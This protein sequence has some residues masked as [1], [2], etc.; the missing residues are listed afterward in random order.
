MNQ[1]KYMQ[2]E[3]QVEEAKY[4]RE[5]M[6][7]H[8]QLKPINTEEFD[9]LIPKVKKEET[10]VETKGLQFKVLSPQETKEILTKNEQPKTF[11][12]SKPKVIT[13]VETK[14][15]PSSNLGNIKTK[16]LPKTK[17]ILET[18]K[19]ELLSLYDELFDKLTEGFSANKVE[20]R[21]IEIMEIDELKEYL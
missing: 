6:L 19:P 20:D 10:K 4:E 11:E 14:V 13:P 12:F 17:E 3:V 9:N 7:K 15:M 16:E 18:E 21:N 5:M 8:G 1:V 2:P